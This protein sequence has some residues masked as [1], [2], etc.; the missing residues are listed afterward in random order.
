[1]RKITPQDG[2]FEAIEL[3][4]KSNVEVIVMPAI[5]L[6]FKTDVQSEATFEGHIAPSGSSGYKFFGTL[7]A[8]CR[9]NRRSTPFRNTVRL[10]HG[11]SSAEFTYLAF[12]LEGPEDNT[13]S[14]EGSGSRKPNETVDFRLGFNEGLSGDFHDGSKTTASVG[15]PSQPLEPFYIK[16]D[17]YDNTSYDV[18][19]AGTARA[20]GPNN[21]VIEGTLS[22]YSMAGALTTQYASFGY[23]TASGSWQYKTFACDDTPQDF[24]IYGSRKSGEKIKA[25][26]GAT[27]QIANLYAYGEEVSCELPERF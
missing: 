14:V 22:A 5:K 17:A 21:F 2:L 25:L 27:S 8:H 6:H 20:D 9:L 11:G 7:T 23:K 26:V 1:M 10:G 18:R 12:T 15:G 16:Q 3:I 4:E 13:F 24:K 19:F